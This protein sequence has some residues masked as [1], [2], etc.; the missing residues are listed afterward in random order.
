MWAGPVNPGARRSGPAQAQRRAIL[1]RGSPRG[2][3]GRF[4]LTMNSFGSSAAT[5]CQNC[6][7]GKT[8]RNWRSWWN[9]FFSNGRAIQLNRAKTSRAYACGAATGIYWRLIRRNCASARGANSRW[10]ISC[11]IRRLFTSAK[12]LCI[13]TR[14]E[15]EQSGFVGV[16][17]TVLPGLG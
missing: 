8:L 11:R 17:E 16:G 1:S 2:T 7:F 14:D 9:L 5:S 13:A 15:I 6:I 3:F 10:T 4:I 12:T